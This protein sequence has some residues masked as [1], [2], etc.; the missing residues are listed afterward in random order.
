[1]A[2][3]W[4]V[5]HSGYDLLSTHNDQWLNEQTPKIDVTTQEF[6]R[7]EKLA[8]PSRREPETTRWP[9]LLGEH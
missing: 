3:K 5:S 7:G 1:M 9:P 8:A 6:K 2:S 4:S